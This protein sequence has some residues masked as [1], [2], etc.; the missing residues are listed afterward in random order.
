MRDCWDTG[1]DERK[2]FSFFLNSIFILAIFIFRDPFHIGHSNP[3]KDGGWEEWKDRGKEEGNGKEEGRN[4]GRQEG[5]M[6]E[7]L[8]FGL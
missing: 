7:L 2:L 5:G 4:K 6:D 8:N 1:R 3:G